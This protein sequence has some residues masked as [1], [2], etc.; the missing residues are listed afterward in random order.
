M[1]LPAIKRVLNGLEETALRAI[2]SEYVEVEPQLL[3]ILR[4]CTVTGYENTG[5][6]FF[7]NL[8]LDRDRFKPINLHSPLSEAFLR[9]DGMEYGIGCLIFLT[10]GY[11]ALLEGYSL[12]GEDTSAID[13]G[14]VGFSVRSGP[15]TGSD[16]ENGRE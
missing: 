13:F 5:S 12:A 6:G 4:S 8:E 15:P 11:P 16:L 10:D 14:A 1:D 7:A 2:A 9:I 3:A